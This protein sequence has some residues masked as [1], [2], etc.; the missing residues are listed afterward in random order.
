MSKPLNLNRKQGGQT[1][2]I[3]VLILGVLLIL[4]VAF[5]A[6]VSRNITQLGRSHQRTVAGDLADAG[7]RF[8]HYQ[9]LYSG[10]GADWKPTPT[11]LTVDPQ[12]FTKDPD[13]LYLRPRPVPDRGLRNAAD[14]QVDLGGPDGL[15]PYSRIMNDRGRYLIRVRYAPADFSTFAN[16]VGPMRVPGRARRYLILESVGRPT[17]VRPGDPTTLS[18]KAVKVTNYADDLDYRNSLQVMRV[19]DTRNANQRKLM[20]MASIGIIE[21]AR[22]IT[23]K[24]RVNRPAEIGYPT[25]GDQSYEG[26]PV[27]VASLYGGNLQ[28]GPTTGIGMGS[29]YCNTDLRV[30]GLNEFW[31]NRNLGDNL[32]VAGT[33]RGSDDNSGFRFRVEGDPT[34]YD[35]RNN[36]PLSL[37]SRDQNFTTIQGLL[38]D[39][40]P[41][42]DALGYTR[43]GAYKMPPS[44]LANDPATNTN[45]YLFMTRDSG[46]LDPN[47]GFQRGRNGY[48]SGIYVDAAERGNAFSEDEREAVEVSKSLPY[49]WLNPN[50]PNSVGWQGPYYVPLASYLRLRPDGFEIIRDSR[51]ARRYWRT[52]DN[53]GTTISKMRFR[54]RYVNGQAYVI[55]SIVSA[56][57]IDQV[58]LPDTEFLNNGRPFNGV[59][60]FEGDVRVRGVI[61]THFQLT[62]ASRGSIYVEGSITKGVVDERGNLLSEPSRSMLMLMAK[63]YC[64]V[65]TT[66]FFGPAAGEVARPKN[67]D[68]LP[69]TPNPVEIDLT[70]A[71]AL[72]L[73]TQ[74][75]LEQPTGANRLIPQSWLPYANRYTEFGNGSAIS[76]SLLLT[77]AADDNGPSFINLNIVPDTFADV[78][79][80]PVEVYEFAR[81][82]SFGAAGTVDF[83]GAANVFTGTGNVPIYGLAN[84]SINAFPKFESIALPLVGPGFN[85]N[86]RQLQPPNGN[87]T[88]NYRLATQDESLMTLRLTAAGNFSPKNY[89]LARTAVTPHDIRIE[90]AMYAE[91]GSFFVIPGP[92]FNY[93]P[94]DSRA[95]FDAQVTNLGSLEAAQRDRFER[96]G[97]APEFPFY[98]EPLDVRV[99]IIGAVSENMTAPIS[100]QAEWLKKWGWIPRSMGGTGRLIPNQH[101]PAGYNLQGTD[102]Y[103]PNLI[104]SYDPA[105]ATAGV[106]ALP[107]QYVPI[108]MT[109]D[110]Q[111]LPPMPLL[112]VSPTLAYFGDYNP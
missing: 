65:N 40:E 46:S 28:V 21:S 61:P 41:D 37:D 15:G 6:I 43:Y 63:D 4:G 10:L 107:G 85:Y 44:F 7:V 76:P 30:F 108:R 66:Q 62:V 17:S 39:G 19:E 8:A 79:A 74:F 45:R 112:P 29:F 99:Q 91:E 26:Q 36:T 95:A 35:L 50:N 16:P 22:F 69:N 59:I 38:R 55:N 64:V 102:R 52:P 49:D 90:C 42:T 14:P 57:V 12:G 24:D 33:I 110:G 2:I 1:L 18:S 96:Y 111:E 103:V 48:G 98:G 13:T 84:P 89:A 83:N 87:A 34:V 53:Q 97:V 93:N 51:S 70:E 77:H 31:L 68:I 23:D 47:T 82:L 58:N 72:T 106:E 27:N 105:L 100:Q 60:Y 11:P 81:Q 78:G 92:S 9:L 75:L 54:L 104:I 25:G 56:A 109:R 88:G 67:A 94:E 80:A 3:A 73:N 71:P 5:A 86:N 32:I 101:T 20:A